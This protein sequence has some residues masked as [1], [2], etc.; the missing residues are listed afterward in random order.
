VRVSIVAVAVLG[1]FALVALAALVFG[2]SFE[3]AALLAPA[4]VICIG[5]VVA[6]VVLWTK[7]ALEPWRRRRDPSDPP[8]SVSRP[9]ELDDRTLRAGRRS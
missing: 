5:G 7:A 6:L 8:R 1:T 3:R 2:L 4:I 9:D